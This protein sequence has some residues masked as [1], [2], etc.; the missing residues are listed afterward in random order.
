MK[1][2]DEILKCI[3]EGDTSKLESLVMNLY[4]DVRDFSQSVHVDQEKMDLVINDK[5][6]TGE[7]R[8]DCKNRVREWVGGQ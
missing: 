4:N 1:K 2:F 7:Y 6:G 3:N 8:V 5:G